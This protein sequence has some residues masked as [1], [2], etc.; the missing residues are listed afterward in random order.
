MDRYI[1]LDAHASSCTLAVVGPSGKR[2]GSHVVETNA[3]AL[4][5]VLRGIPKSRHMCLEEGTLTGW[6][7]EVLEPHVEEL[8]VTGVGKSRGPKSDKR[9]AF[10]LAEQLRIG[11][12]KTRVYKGRGQ[13]MRLGNLAKAYGFLVGDTVR[14]KNRLRSVLRSRGVGYGAGQSVYAKREREQ[15]LGKL[16]EATMAQ[17]GLLYEEHD[18]L[19]A[20]RRKAEKAMLA[21][22]RKHRE[23]ARADDVPG[24]GP[25]PDRRITAGCGDTVPVQKP[26]RILGVLRPGHRDAELVGL[27]AS[28]DGGVDEDAGAA[29]SGPEPQLQPHAEACVQGGRPAATT[30]IGRAEEGP[31]YRHYLSLLDGGTKHFKGPCPSAVPSLSEP[32]HPRNLPLRGCAQGEVYAHRSSMQGSDERMCGWA[33]D[34]ERTRPRVRDGGSV[35]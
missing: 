31:L 6:L 7:H 21:E 33:R 15:W 16:P 13:F 3:R 28:L 35:E 34:A 5:E 29:D 20:L 17:A 1:G 2:L 22:A 10:G 23:L 26:E 4:I 25:D 19:V 11:A 14:V 24:S 8:V 18:A 32:R 12:I 9:D 30:V 27:G